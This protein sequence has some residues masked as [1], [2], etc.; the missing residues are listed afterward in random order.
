LKDPYGG[1]SFVERSMRKR[2][3]AASEE[4]EEKPDAEKPEPDKTELEKP[5]VEVEAVP[6]TAQ[7][8]TPVH[9]DYVPATT[10]DGLEHVGTLNE[11]W[12]QPP[13]NN[14]RFVTFVP[15]L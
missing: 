2:R 14:D 1:E 3:E 15:A 11:W 7:E 12:D 13:T 8:S 10:W 4:V 5:Q 9:D 6:A